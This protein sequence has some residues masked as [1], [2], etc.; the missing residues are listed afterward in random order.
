MRFT[1]SSVQPLCSTRHGSITSTRIRTRWGVHFIHHYGDLT[2]SS[3]LI[4][5]GQDLNIRELAALVCRVLDFE[6]EL[7]FDTR[8]QTAHRASCS[9]SAASAH[10]AGTHR[11][12]WNKVFD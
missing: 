12:A 7:V 9:M 10:W 4:R 5:I 8:N 2:D 1:A 3:N 11:P 6:C